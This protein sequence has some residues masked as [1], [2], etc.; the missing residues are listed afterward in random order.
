MK[1]RAI[2][3][4]LAAVLLLASVVLAQGTPAIEW[5]VMGGGGGHVEAAPYALD[6]TIGQAVVGRAAESGSELYS[7][8]WCGVTAAYSVYLPIVLRSF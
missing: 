6:G 7:G 4:T 2:S 5:D 1:R 8:F 3:L